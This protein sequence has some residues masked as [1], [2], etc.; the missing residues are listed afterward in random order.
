MRVI[1]V[2]DKKFIKIYKKKD[3]G[4]GTRVLYAHISPAVAGLGPSPDMH[5]V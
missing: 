4:T 1:I 3:N 5:L 2:I